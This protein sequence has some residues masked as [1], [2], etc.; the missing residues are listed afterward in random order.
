MAMSEYVRG[1]RE[2]VGNDLL[3][4][5]GVSAVVFNDG[6]EILLV[7]R[8][9]NGQWSTPAGA[10][11]PDEQPADA[12]VREV[13]EETGVHCVVERVSGVGMVEATYP[14]GDRCQYL[15]IWFRGRATGGTAR[16]NDDES[17]EV[18]WFAPEGLP[19]MSPLTRQR[20]ELA[21]ADRPE[22]WF[23]PAGQQAGPFS[24]FG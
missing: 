18:A 24:L 16:V 17:T 14:N 10:I 5:P 20:I 13:L 15:S 9:D 12:I 2:H 7:R 8:A 3:L 6:G 4:L 21:L 11:D 19:E 1:L 23:A 22:A